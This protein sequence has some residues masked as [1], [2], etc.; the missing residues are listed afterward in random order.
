M[1]QMP[2]STFSM[3][4]S[5]KSLDGFFGLIC[6][7]IQLVLTVVLP[8]PKPEFTAAARATATVKVVL[9][10]TKCALSDDTSS[11]PYVAAMGYAAIV[12]S[13]LFYILTTKQFSIL[14]TPAS[15]ADKLEG[16]GTGDQPP[17]PPSDPDTESNAKKRRNRWPL[18][19]LIFLIWTVLLSLGASLFVTYLVR[20]PHVVGYL[21]TGTPELIG[22]LVA[23]TFV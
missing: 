5:S 12:L 16:S 2:T 18:F 10:P 9:Q 13:G 4:S 20:T 22:R 11:F 19:L 21:F 6:V 7:G 1:L 8:K 23:D 15:H 14:R 17:S 3:F